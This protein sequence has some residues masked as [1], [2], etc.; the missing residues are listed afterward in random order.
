MLQ[1]EP[2]GEETAAETKAPK[3]VA[4]QILIAT[5]KVINLQSRLGMAPSN[6]PDAL[7]GDVTPA[8]VYEAANRLLVELARIKAHLDIE[9]PAPER[10]ETR[11]MQSGDVYAQMLRLIADLDRLS[12]AAA[13]RG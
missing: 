7:L 4:Q 11:R 2:P 5:Y 13:G 3:E 1:F 9:S 6:V 10:Y 8:D 12:K